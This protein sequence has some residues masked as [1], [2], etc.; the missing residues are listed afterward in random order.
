MN[1]ITLIKYSK[2]A[3]FKYSWDIP[4]VVC[5]LL[6]FRIDWD[7]INVYFDLEKLLLWYCL[8]NSAGNS[9]LESMTIV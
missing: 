6:A 8:G 2:H 7:L 4:N 5:N 3:Y 1:N 9:I